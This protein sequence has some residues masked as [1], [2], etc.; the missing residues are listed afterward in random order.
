MTIKHWITGVAVL[1]FL[2]AALCLYLWWTDRDGPLQ[3]IMAQA[4]MDPKG[5][6][7][8]I[9]RKY[10]LGTSSAVL[11]DDLRSGRYEI[12]KAPRG[13]YGITYDGCPFGLFGRRTW[14][15]SWD[16]EQDRLTRIKA[17]LGTDCL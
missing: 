15:I 3:I 13:Y 5:A 1:G 7:L 2:A 16:E 8:Q 6:E 12:F 10:P 11:R 4:R 17:T 9:V 14:V